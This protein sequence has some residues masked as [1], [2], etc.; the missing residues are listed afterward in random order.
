MPS[1]GISGALALLDAIE[2]RADDRRRHHLA[3]VV[4]AGELLERDA[5]D[6]ALAEHRTTAVAGVDRGVDGDRE[7]VA[8]AVAVALD[9]DAR[10][11]ALGDRD[12]LA[13]DRVADH[14][15]LVAQPRHVADLGGLDIVKEIRWFDDF[16][17]GEVAVVADRLHP[18]DRLV[19]MRTFWIWRNVALAT[20]CAPVSRK[21]L[22]MTTA[23]PVLFEGVR[24]CH[25]PSKSGS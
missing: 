18:G 2:E 4:D 16:E 20:T 6:L 11:D 10:D 15:D 8:L 19:R 17:Q 3:D 13:A 9:L 1:A 14:G 22:P 21:P 23:E 5:D 24:A 12:F 25:G 7:Q